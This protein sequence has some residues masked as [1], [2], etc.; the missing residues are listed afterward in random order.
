MPAIVFIATTPTHNEVIFR[1]NEDLKSVS[2]SIGVVLFKLAEVV[3]RIGLLRSVLIDVKY[4]DGRRIPGNVLD[5]YVIS[6]E[7]PY[8]EIV[9]PDL[10]EALTEDQKEAVDIIRQC[11]V[12]TKEIE[13]LNQLSGCCCTATVI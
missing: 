4:Q 12:T 5:Y 1:V 6:L 11:L 8:R 10:T 2:L 3:H 7:L 9:V 13:K